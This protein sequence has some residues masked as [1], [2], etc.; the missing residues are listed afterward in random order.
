MLFRIKLARPVPADRNRPDVIQKRLDYANWSMSHAVVNHIVFTDECGYNIWTSG[1]QGRARR[2]ERD[3]RQVCGQ[4]GRNVTVR[5]AILP[6][7]ALV[8]YSEVI[9]GMNALRFDDFL[10]LMNMLSSFMTEC[11]PTIIR[12]FLVP[13]QN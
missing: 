12:L 10:I 1:G 3:Y 2:G 9:G 4:Q 11:Q 7:N 6:T 13:T 8:F 5:M